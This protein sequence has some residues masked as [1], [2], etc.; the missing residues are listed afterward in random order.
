LSLFNNDMESDVYQ[1]VIRTHYDSNGIY[2][3][4]ED[5]K[6]KTTDALTAV[7]KDDSI[8]LHIPFDSIIGWKKRLLAFSI[9]FFKKIENGA[10]DYTAGVIKSDLE[11]AK[12][13]RF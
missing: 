6:H 5:H 1:T 13:I 11:K 8:L 9:Y 12:Y 2:A 3:D 7:Q 10:Y 4:L